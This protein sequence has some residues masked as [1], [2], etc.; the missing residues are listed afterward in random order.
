M[1]DSHLFQSLTGKREFLLSRNGE[2]SHFCAE[3][4]GHRIQHSVVIYRKGALGN[5]GHIGGKLLASY[6]ADFPSFNLHTPFRWK[7]EAQDTFEES[8]LSNSIR[9]QNSNGFAS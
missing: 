8:A 9:A 3:A 6:F 1:G 2:K 4:H 7:K 5:V